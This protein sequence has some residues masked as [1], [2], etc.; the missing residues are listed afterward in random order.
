MSL[1]FTQ[2]NKPVLSDRVSY[3][4]TIITGRTTVPAEDLNNQRWENGWTKV[5]YGRVIEGTYR[6]KVIYNKRIT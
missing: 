2:Y 5:I 3:K 4:T 6:N 1:Q